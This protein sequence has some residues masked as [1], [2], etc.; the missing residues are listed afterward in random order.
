MIFIMCYINNVKSNWFRAEPRRY[1]MVKQNIYKIYSDVEMFAECKLYVGAVVDYDDKAGVMLNL[2][3]G[4]DDYG[5]VE[6]AFGI[7]LRQ[8]LEFNDIGYSII[9]VMSND[10]LLDDIVEA[11]LYDQLEIAQTGTRFSFF[12]D[13][14]CI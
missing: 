2:Y 4:S 7:P 8:Y 5:I 11:F 3:I 14:Y 1:V 6:F 13:D 9:E 12:I 10:R